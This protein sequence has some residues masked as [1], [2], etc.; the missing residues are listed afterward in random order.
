MS[1]LNATIRCFTKDKLSWL[2][3]ITGLAIGLT[4][5]TCIALYVEHELSFDKFHSGWENTYRVVTDFVNTDGSLVHDA[6]TPPA[7]AK[8]LRPD[9]TGVETATRFSRSGGRLYLMQY[10][11]KT[12]YETKL[13][14][15]DKEF[16]HVFDFHFIAGNKERCLEQ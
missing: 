14:S 8:A 12:F 16:F 1:T 6:T 2:I 7:L 9:L 4:G 5:F 3:N 15:V 13:V 10:Q 11:D